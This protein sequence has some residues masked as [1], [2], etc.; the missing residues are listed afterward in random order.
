[1]IYVQ[2]G[3]VGTAMVT[4]FSPDGTIDY[5]QTA[6]LLEH[7]IAN[8]TDSV[9]VSGTTGESPTLTITEKKELL[10]FVIKVVNKRIPVIAGTGTNNTTESIELTKAA[11]LSG[12]DGIMLVTPYYNK[13]DQKGMYAHFSKIANVT[14]LPVLLYNIPSRSIV[15]LLPETVIALS[16]I[17][18]IK[19]VKEASGNLEQMAEIIEGTAEDF[20]VYSGDDGLTL[21]LLAIGGRG[22][23]SVSA[24]VVGNEMQ[25][26]IQAFQNGNIKE[27][28]DL[29]RSLLPI[30]KALFSKPNPVPVKYALGK[31]GVPTGGVRLP[32]IEM[33]ES[34]AAIIDEVLEKFEKRTRIL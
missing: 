22:I 7:L 34:E 30:F 13:P 31:A 24:H 8:G 9:I 14:A 21:P 11:E 5:V 17:D 16:K 15:N 10:D 32:L 3:N 29:H 4:P 18:N 33:D 25:K 27:A 6:I 20:E 12:A 1:M 2:L 19:A 26:M 23:I 28:A